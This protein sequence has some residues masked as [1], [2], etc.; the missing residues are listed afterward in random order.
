MKISPRASTCAAVLLAVAG[1]Y[2]WQQITMTTRAMETQISAAGI[3]RTGHFFSQDLVLINTYDAAY[4]DTNNG[5]DLQ[6][7][8]PESG[9]LSINLI[10][11]VIY[12]YDYNDGNK[13]FQSSD[14]GESWT[15]TGQFPFT[16]AGAY[17][18]L[19][20][21]PI[22][23]TVFMVMQYSFPE[24]PGP[25]RGIYKSTDYGAT[26]SKVSEGAGHW[27]S[28]IG[29]SPD[30]A[31]D[32]TAFITFGSYKVTLGA[33]KT[34]DW[35]DT[36]SHCD[37]LPSGGSLTGHLLAISPQFARDQTVFALSDHGLYK[38]TDG[39]ILW[40]YVSDIPGYHPTELAI[41]PGYLDDQ[42]LFV[43]DYEEGLFL[44]QD[45][46]ESWKPINFGLSPSQV[47]IRLVSPYRPWPTLPRPDPSG[48]YRVY[49]PFIS[50]HRTGPHEL[51]VI[52]KTSMEDLVVHLYR[53]RDSGATWE[54][55]WVF[56]RSD[57]LY[58]PLVSRA[59]IGDW[60]FVHRHRHLGGRDWLT[61]LP[62]KPPFYR[63]AGAVRA[64]VP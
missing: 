39:G 57:W 10:G 40:Q 25:F 52:T 58:L 6:E 5:W 16:D 54:E 3:T 43:G 37:D 13:I 33:W 49:F 42:T 53:S 17:E 8:F 36:W 31:H 38:S 41:S 62:E 26:W 56:E 23:N 61:R 63:Q 55:L 7:N 35:G 9:A 4:R 20:A 32:G 51:W 30:F 28:R 19:S 27:A 60:A 2:L 14:G 1:I 47:G 45:G 48:P 21:S 22:T 12:N 11:E 50:S 24:P 44:S 18:S 46:G 64:G 59:S 34:E 29:F 15:L